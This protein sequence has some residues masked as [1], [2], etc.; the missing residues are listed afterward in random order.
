MGAHAEYVRVS[1]NGMVAVKPTN[2]QFEEPAAVLYG[3]VAA[4]HFLKQAKIKPG[5][6]VL[7]YAASGGV[8][9]LFNS[10]STSARVSRA[11]AARRTWN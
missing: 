3:G 5:Q 9:V 7:I 11:S 8:G 1:E 4:V 10:P 2:M 6:N